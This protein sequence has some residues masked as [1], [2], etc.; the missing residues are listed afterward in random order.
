MTLTDIIAKITLFA[1]RAIVNDN[2]SNTAASITQSGTGAALIVNKSNSGD[3]VRIT[4]TGGG[5]AF[6]VEDSS[7][8]DSTPFLINSNGIVVKGSAESKTIGGIQHGIQANAVSTDQGASIGL[9]RYNNDSAP[10]WLSFAKS[11]GSVNSFGLIQN[12]DEIGKINFVADN[13]SNYD[14]IRALIRAIA[15][16]AVSSG[17]IPMSLCFHTGAT[18]APERVRIDPDGNVGINTTNPTATLHVVGTAT[19]SG[20]TTIGSPK[21]TGLST[22]ANNVDAV[23]GGL[24]VNTIYK[25]ATGELRIVI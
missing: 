7:N 24:A 21:F 17:S 20:A 11:R 5:N 8:P 12:G 19:I 1:K 14:S 15:D 9:L 25:T 10:P 16:G 6:V 4:Q 13:G 18:S 23:T 22:Y 2:S 3:A